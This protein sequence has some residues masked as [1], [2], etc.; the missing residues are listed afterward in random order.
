MYCVLII[1]KF[2][3]L[4]VLFFIFFLIDHN[5]LEGRARLLLYVL[6]S[7]SLIHSYSAA[8]GST[9][10]EVQAHC[11]RSRGFCPQEANS[12]LRG[13]RGALGLLTDGTNNSLTKTFINKGTERHKGCHALHSMFCN[14]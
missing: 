14:N 5:L 6:S 7:H 11:T 2:L 4:F 13:P 3:L 10:Y 12:S 1:F 8:Q 9:G